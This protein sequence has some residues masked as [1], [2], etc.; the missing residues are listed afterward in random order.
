MVSL[1]IAIT[2]ACVSAAIGFFFGRI[3]GLLQACELFASLHARAEKKWAQ[4]AH[5]Y[6]AAAEQAL[7]S[8]R[9]RL[10]G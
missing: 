8:Q 7:E 1:G 5:E 6:R 10:N 2:A 9:S 4:Q 3:Y